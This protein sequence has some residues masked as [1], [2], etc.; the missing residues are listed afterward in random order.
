MQQLGVGNAVTTFTASDFARTLQPASG[1]G[2]DHAWGNHQFVMG[3]A[4]KADLW[5]H[6][7]AGAQWAGR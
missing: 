6:A 7:A 4:V 1:G 3:G 2:T 5:P